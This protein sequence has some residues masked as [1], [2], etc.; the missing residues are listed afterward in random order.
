MLP[1]PRHAEEK[2]T[3]FENQ[4]RAKRN[5]MLLVLVYVLA[6]ILIVAAVYGCVML[7]WLLMLSHAEDPRLL[8]SG[9][10]TLWYPSVF[11]NVMG[12]TLAIVI[13]GTL[14]KIL[15][16]SRG[17]SAVA[18]LLGGRLIL[19]NSPQAEEKRVL[20]V[21]EEMAIAS[22]IPVPPVY[23][24]PEKSINAF[25]A[26]FSPSSAVIGVTE[27]CVQVLSRDELQG[28]IAHE[29]SHIL[30]GDMRLNIRLVGVLNGIL[31]IGLI[32]YA[33]FRMGLEVSRGSRRS[34]SSGGGAAFA[35]LGVLL[36]LLGYVG[37]F[38]ANIIKS[39]VSRQREYL[40]DASA[41]QF[42]RNPSGIAK[43]L[44]KIG[45]FKSGSTLQHPRAQEVSH[46]F[47]ANGITQTFLGL[48]ATHPPLIERI[49][50][51]EPGLASA[52]AR[53]GV[54]EDS[55]R[56]AGSDDHIG[57][58]AAG[59]GAA[60]DAPQVPLAQV[61]QTV[62]EVR[63]AHL[64]FAQ[65]FQQALSESVSDLARDPIGAQAVM[66]ALL[67]SP[68]QAVQRQQ[69]AYLSEN[70]NQQVLRDLA[71]A[72]PTVTKL[73]PGY[74]MPL[75]NRLIASLRQL[76][77]RAYQNFRTQIQYLIEIDKQ[78]SLFEYALQRSLRR[79]LDVHFFP[80]ETR[81]LS[82]VGLLEEGEAALQLLVCI[83][84]LSHA[85]PEAAGLAIEAGLKQLVVL[86]LTNR[87]L[88]QQASLQALDDCLLALEQSPPRTRESVLRACAAAVAVDRV[89]SVTEAE[90]LRAVAD[91]LECPIPPFLPA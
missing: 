30:N 90:L 33:L 59:L 65:G 36:Y 39:A 2:M 4:I 56:E 52:F 71:V 85:N 23:L 76:P 7:V 15:Q 20:N 9:M 3:F 55:G 68:D 34:E 14:F 75:V 41:V 58:S 69:L 38:F 25:A 67:L 8:R 62:G 83:A 54:V 84:R 77:A 13:S 51:I 72:Q 26:G 63:E 48:F 12:V 29:F 16:L 49:R 74:R 46:L 70:T 43:A 40:A 73:Q 86:G 80:R 44:A 89:V 19:P 17:G 64:R 27:G 91:G 22:G 21:V 42:T 37:V 11:Y 81:D 61:H 50:R 6:V 45:G 66:F 82:A 87:P 1:R 5:T 10:H 88:P 32:G 78:C 47:F 57:F 60:V 31:M 35:A 53:G 18:D 28:V 24:I 79:H